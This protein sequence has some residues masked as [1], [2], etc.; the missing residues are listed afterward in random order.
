MQKHPQYFYYYLIK[1]MKKLS[2]FI[3]LCILSFFVYAQEDTLNV[4]VLFPYKVTIDKSC[5]TAYKETD[6][7]ITDGRTQIIAA[8][9]QQKDENLAE[10][11]SQPWY[12]KQVFENQVS[13]MN[14]LSLANQISFQVQDFINYRLGKPFK[15]KPRLVLISDSLADGSAASYKRRGSGYDF[16]YNIT[17]INIS[18][19]NKDSA[20]ATVTTQLYNCKSKQ[21]VYNKTNTGDTKARSYD[22]TRCNDG[23]IDCAILNAAYDSMHECLFIIAKSVRPDFNK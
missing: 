9:K 21:V 18:K 8:M 16:I 13:M 10:F 20:I 3:T 22:I 11:E 12:T 23:D 15:I 2:L 6:T 14:K 4:L 1:E 5:S 17:S 7:K 19:N